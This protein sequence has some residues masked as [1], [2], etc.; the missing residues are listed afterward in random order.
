MDK[1]LIA[2]LIVFIVNGILSDIF[3]SKKLRKCSDRLSELKK[4]IFNDENAFG[5]ISSDKVTAIV[6]I[7]NQV[8]QLEACCQCPM[9]QEIGKQYIRRRFE[10]SKEKGLS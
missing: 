8:K 2:I 3:I 9:Y 4:V 10:Q 1:F 5:S 6:Q 7:E